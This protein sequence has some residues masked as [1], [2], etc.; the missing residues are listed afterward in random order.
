MTCFRM[1]DG[2]TV[3]QHCIKNGLDYKRVYELMDMGMPIDKAI[4]HY[5][6][7]RGRKDC[8]L[9]YKYREGSARRHC[10]ENKLP[11]DMFLYYVHAGYSCDK[12]MDI[13]HRKRHFKD[14]YKNPI[15][16]IKK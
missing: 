7:R 15:D 12:A 14:I 3:R 13:V 2:T 4:K 8:R 5:V 6:E 9:V 16:N 11:Y 10:M 1:P